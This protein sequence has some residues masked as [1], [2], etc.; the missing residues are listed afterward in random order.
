MCYQLFFALF[1][2]NSTVKFMRKTFCQNICTAAI[3]A[4]N[5]LLQISEIVLNKKIQ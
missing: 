4:S 2:P 1:V 5:T 3:N